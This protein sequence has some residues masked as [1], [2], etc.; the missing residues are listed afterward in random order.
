MSKG[1]SIGQRQILQKL[2][3]HEQGVPVAWC[4]LDYGST[5]PERFFTP[6]GQHSMA[7]STRRAL[8]NLEMRGLVTLARYSFHPWADISQNEFRRAMQ[9]VD[10]GWSYRHP[11][12]HVPGQSR[13]M[14]GVLLTEEGRRVAQR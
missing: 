13:I 14:T 2:L 5:D 4:D 11:S 8:R 3:R 6:E 9:Q 10:M 7:Q 1:I 12:E